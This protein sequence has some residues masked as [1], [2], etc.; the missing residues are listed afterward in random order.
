MRNWTTAP[1]KAGWVMTRVPKVACDS[2]QYANADACLSLSTQAGVELKLGT[3]TK[4]ARLPERASKEVR[5]IVYCDLD[6]IF[7]AIS[8]ESMPSLAT[9]YKEELPIIAKPTSAS[10]IGGSDRREETRNFFKTS[11]CSRGGGAWFEGKVGAADCES[12][13]IG[14]RRPLHR[15]SAPHW[16]GPRKWGPESGVGRVGKGKFTLYYGDLKMRISKREEVSTSRVTKPRA[17]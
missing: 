7:I 9:H 13:W 11:G 16:H 10:L 5:K 12:R 17:S 15:M 2:I 4:L 8:S 14:R 6:V 1:P 3:R